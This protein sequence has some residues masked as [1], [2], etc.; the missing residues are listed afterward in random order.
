MPKSEQQAVAL[1]PASQTGSPQFCRPR[2]SLLD[3]STLQYIHNSAQTI[4]ETTGLNV[5]HAEMRERLAARGA[6]LGESPRVFIPMALVDRAV[7]TASKSIVVDDRLGRPAMRLEPREI[8]FGTGSDLVFTRDVNT[9]DRRP[10]RL[11]DTADSARLCDALDEIDF[12]MSFALPQEIAVGDVETQQYYAMLSNTVKPV[13][14]TSFSGLETL[15]RMHQMACLVA[16]GAEAFRSR[17]NYV[18][19]SQFV[20]PLQ[21][22]RLAIE[23]LIFCAEQGV[24]LIYIPTIMCGASGPLTLLGSLALALAETLAGL[25]MHQTWLPGAP[26]ITGACVSALDMRTGLFPYDTAEWRLCDLAMAEISRHYGIPVFGTAGA[27]D[28]KLVDAQ[29]GADYASSLLMTALAGTNI[30]HDVGYLESGLTGSLESI[31]LGVEKIR[32]VKRILAGIE[33]SEETLAADVIEEIGPA[34]DFLVHDHTFKHL[35]KTV[36]TPLVVDHRD[37][38]SWAAEGA[39][40]YRERARLYAKDI[41]ASHRPEPVDRATDIALRRLSNLA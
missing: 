32:W 36:S 40:E 3:L 12:V 17:P 41:I 28:S 38:D 5:H 20:S 22:D 39:L 26:F 31:V 35:R 33:V 16:G 10:S 37:Y 23:R 21:H 19:Y 1:A 11:S 7:Q 30:I 27:T 13:I 34:R 2:L 14:M 25:A 8:Y 29:A 18:M 9:G 15:Q 4:L 24:P 6:R